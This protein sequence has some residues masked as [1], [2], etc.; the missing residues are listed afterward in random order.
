MVTLPELSEPQPEPTCTGHPDRISYVRCQRCEKPVCPDCQ[1]TAAVGVQCV[2]CVREEAKS[3]RVA[4]SLFGGR[5]TTGRPLATWSIMASCVVVFLLQLT[6]GRGLSESLR[7]EDLLGFVPAK[8]EA[9]PWRLV[10]AGFLHSTSFTPHI[11]LNMLA[12]YQIGPILEYTFGRLRFLLLYLISTVGGSIAVLLLADPTTIA[13]TTIVIGAS[14]AVFGL[15]G[16]LLWLQRRLNASINGLFIIVGLNFFFGFM[17]SGVSWQSHLGGFITGGLVGAAI[18]L[19]PKRWRAR[20]Q[21]CGVA[22]V[23]ALLTLGYFLG[24][25]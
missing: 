17:L 25:K 14:G 10:T 16:A 11:F 8:A 12:F 3:S 22:A 13:W 4:R 15:F 20:V 9:E 21:G 6:T 1:K 23:C 24:V 19:P 18:V 2:D 7:L 5:A